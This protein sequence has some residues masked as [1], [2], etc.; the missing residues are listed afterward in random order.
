MCLRIKLFYSW[1]MSVLLACFFSGFG[2]MSLYLPSLVNYNRFSVAISLS[3]NWIIKLSPFQIPVF[4]FLVS[5]VVDLN[6][7]KQQ[8]AAK[9]DL[10]EQEQNKFKTD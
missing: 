10:I 1:R 2:Q 4:T 8:L 7:A 6:L 3:E 9:V 5:S